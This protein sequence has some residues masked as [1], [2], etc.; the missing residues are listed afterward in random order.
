MIPQLQLT[1]RWFS[2]FMMEGK[3]RMIVL[4]SQDEVLTVYQL[5]LIVNISD[6]EWVK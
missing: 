2:I 6:E 1:R 4:R 3:Q 5:L